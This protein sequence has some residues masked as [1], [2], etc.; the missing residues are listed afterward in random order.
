LFGHDIAHARRS[1]CVRTPMLGL[2][3]SCSALHIAMS[4][5]RFA[6]ICAGR[7]EKGRTTPASSATSPSSSSANPWRAKRCDP[8]RVGA[9]GE[10]AFRV[11][12]P[13]QLHASREWTLDHL[14]SAPRTFKFSQRWRWACG[15]SAR[16]RRWSSSTTSMRVMSSRMSQPWPRRVLSSSSQVVRI[17]SRRRSCSD[18]TRPPDPDSAARRC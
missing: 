10:I 14:Q 13:L 17:R 1:I 4:A 8:L 5:A 9:R 18:S 6:S 7:R 12:Q 11:D 16:E 2:A 15:S 3:P